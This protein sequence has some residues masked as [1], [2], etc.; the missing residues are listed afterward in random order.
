M[1]IS[2]LI[3]IP[4]AILLISLFNM[5]ACAESI[6][7]QKPEILLEMEN[8][9]AS[10]SASNGLDPSDITVI[11]NSTGTGGYVASIKCLNQTKCNRSEVTL[12]FN[13]DEVDNFSRTS[14]QTQL[15]KS[16][17]NSLLNSSPR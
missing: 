15:L 12:S 1:F 6:S 7:G 9:I 5:N 13:K 8:E 2:L 10:V 4:T 14:M 17:L 3:K 11:W 16:K